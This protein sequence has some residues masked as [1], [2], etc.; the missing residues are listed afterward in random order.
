MENMD[1]QLTFEFEKRIS[2][3]QTFSLTNL[4]SLQEK[5]PKSETYLKLIGEIKPMIRSNVKGVS[6]YTTPRVSQNAFRIENYGFK[7]SV[8]I[9]TMF[10]I[11]HA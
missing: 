8:E 3:G 4:Y 1:A 5:L 11:M 2:E 9:K 7:S 6:Y 10:I